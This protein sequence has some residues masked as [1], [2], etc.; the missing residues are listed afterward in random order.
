[1][2]KNERTMRDAIDA[3]SGLMNKH[4]DAL[5]TINQAATELRLGHLTTALKILDEFIAAYDLTDEE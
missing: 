5:D 4:H 1:M 2:D 3:A